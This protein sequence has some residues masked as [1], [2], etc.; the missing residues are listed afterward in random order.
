MLR[1]VSVYVIVPALF[2]PVYFVVA[3]IIDSLFGNQQLINWLEFDSHMLLLKTF[4]NDWL[5]AIPIMFLIFYILVIPVKILLSIMP[6]K[7]GIT[8]THAIICAGILGLTSL[9]VEFGTLGVITNSISALF[10]VLLYQMTLIS[11]KRSAS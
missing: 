9:F 5:D 1:I 3:N 8:L 6:L 4:F 2:Y 11:T 7:K 10:F